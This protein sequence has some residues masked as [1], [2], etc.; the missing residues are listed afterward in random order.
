M[1][2]LRT[3]CG[4]RRLR[5]LGP[6]RRSRGN[7]TRSPQPQIVTSGQGELSVADRGRLPRLQHGER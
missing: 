3:S 7:A 1:L 5:S 6:I 4:N 2:D